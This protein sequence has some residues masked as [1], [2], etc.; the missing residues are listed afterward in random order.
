MPASRELSTIFLLYPILLCA[1][2]FLCEAIAGLAVT[3]GLTLIQYAPHLPPVLP[4]MTCNFPAE[5]LTGIVG[6]T[7]SCNQL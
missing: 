1:C 7:G 3:Y 4:G 5:K 6:R 2:L